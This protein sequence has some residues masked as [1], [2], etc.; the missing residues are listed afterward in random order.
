[1]TITQFKSKRALNR[2]KTVARILKAARELME[3]AGEDAVTLRKLAR[4]TGLSANT[5][6]RNFGGSRDDIVNAIIMD[7]F[8][9]VGPAEESD[10]GIDRLG[11]APW[12]HAIDQFLNNASFYKAVTLFR[13]SE[14]PMTEAQKHLH[15]LRDRTFEVLEAAKTD[16]L[17]TP[18]ADPAFLVHHFIQ[19][20]LG[21]ADR[22]AKGEIEDETFRKQILYSIYTALIVHSRPAGRKRFGEFLYATTGQRPAIS[23]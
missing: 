22:W 23:S 15:R 18:D 7:A 8:Y 17:L 14:Q 9:D 11:M 2:Q 20:M 1:M 13:T 19:V 16:G 6:Y 21:M 10:L 4:K 5:I 12:D 3:E